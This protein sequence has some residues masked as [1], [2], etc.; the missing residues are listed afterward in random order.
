[1]FYQHACTRTHLSFPGDFQ[2]EQLYMFR[3]Q[4]LEHETG[5]MLNLKV[6]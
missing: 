4:I 5:M 3:C 6:V 2:G 1:M